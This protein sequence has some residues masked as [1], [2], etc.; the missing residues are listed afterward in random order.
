MRRL[1]QPLV[2]RE[3]VLGLGDRGVERE[4]AGEQRVEDRLAARAPVAA[5]GDLDRDLVVREEEAHRGAEIG[6]DGEG[7][8]D[9]AQLGG[10][11]QIGWDRCGHA[12]VL[13][14]EGRA[15]NDCGRLVV[16]TGADDLAR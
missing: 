7:G 16:P 13:P 5:L 4:V 9:L 3:L 8:G 2:A 15:V 1:A 6:A 11:G 12:V 10:P 14:P